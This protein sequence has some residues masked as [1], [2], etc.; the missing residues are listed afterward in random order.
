MSS[1]VAVSVSTEKVGQ[2]IY[3]TGNTFPIKS[4]L[5][6]AGCHWDGDR[7]QW[8]IGAAKAS[9]IASIV[10]KLDG[11]SVAPDKKEL[12]DRPC[13]GKVKYKG[14]DYYVIGRSEKTGNLWLTV[15]DCS[16]DFWAAEGECLWVKR[17]QARER[18]DGRR[19]N[20]T[21]TVHQTVGGIRD[22]IAK[23]KRDDATV[24]SGEVPSGWCVDLEDGCLK[25]RN[26]CDMPAD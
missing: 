26:E 14:R 1:A 4:Q 15:L 6:S 25:P 24:K 21:V 7:K 12:A 18:W 10:G 2:R 22:F 11:K 8:W 9:Q 19:G 13:T 16:I 17:Y 3:V 5:K 20:G 23:S